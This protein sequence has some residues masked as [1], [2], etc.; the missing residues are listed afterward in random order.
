MR[1]ILLSL[2]LVIAA[3]PSDLWACHAEAQDTTAERRRTAQ[4]SAT[5]VAE[6]AALKQMAAA[7]PLGSRVKAQ[8]TSGRQVSGTLMGVS[9]EAVM[10]K[11]KTRLTEPA[12][13]V[14]FAELER[15]ELQLNEGMS[16]GKIVAVGLAAGAGAVLTLIVFALAL[17]D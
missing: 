8:T 16:A 2:V 7:I 10:I 13:T 4:K 12:V 14:E 3:G 1:A 5:A 11:R 15:L 17:D 6:G 9:D